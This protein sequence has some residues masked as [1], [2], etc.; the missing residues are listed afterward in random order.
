[1]AGV[2]QIA[3][4]SAWFLLPDVFF[5]RKVNLFAESKAM[6]GAARSQEAA[7]EQIGVS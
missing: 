5:G 7:A 1:M 6:S 4:N 2:I 3:S